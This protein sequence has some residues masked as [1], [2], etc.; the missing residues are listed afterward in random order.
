MALEQINNMAG[1]SSFNVTD[2]PLNE[3]TTIVDK[4]ILWK[5]N[6]EKVIH[7]LPVILF[8]FIT[9]VVGLVGNSLVCY[10]YSFR[11]RRSP[12]RYFILFLAFLDLISCLV[13]AGSE[14][15]DLFQPYV[16]K[17]TWSCKI[18]RFGLSF[19]I[20]SASFTLICVAFDRYYKVCRPLKAFPVKKVKIL[21]IVVGTLSIMLS[22]PALVIFGLKTVNIGRDGITGSE[23]STADGVRKTALP[24]VYYIILFSA[25]VIL[26]VCFIFLYIKIGLEIWKRKKQTIGETL[27][28][29]IREIKTFQN[30]KTAKNSSVQTEE[31]S[32]RSVQTDEDSRG[33]SEVLSGCDNPGISETD[34]CLN[35][36]NRTDAVNA[37]TENGVRPKRKRSVLIRRR[38][39]LGRMSIRTLRTT[40]IFFTVSAAF[41]LSFLPYLIANILKFTKVAFY[42]FHSTAEEV[43]Y[44][45]CVRSYFISNCI[46]PVIYSALN[47]NFRRECKKLIKRLFRKIRSCCLC[48]NQ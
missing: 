46:N 40:S 11:L 18:L 28:A 15:S 1:Y 22:S 6:S 5:L 38:S 21:C 3:S 47:V 39:S 7:L 20:I 8:I 29:L 4:D 26:L 16:F 43:A 13:G 42:D 31:Q 41:V 9:V 23:C 30:T 14:L 35:T 45:F 2:T 17:A 10:I 37:M 36:I 25:F 24:I 33:P 32:S 27:P 48:Q 12:S 19:T 44:N 34:S